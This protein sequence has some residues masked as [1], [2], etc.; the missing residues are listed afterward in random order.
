MKYVADIS[1]ANLVTNRTINVQRFEGDLNSE[2]PSR[3]TG[4]LCLGQNLS[5]DRLFGELFFTITI[6]RVGNNADFGHK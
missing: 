5:A 4:S 1:F 3:P 2:N 6:N